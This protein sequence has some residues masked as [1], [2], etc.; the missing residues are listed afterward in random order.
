MGNLYNRQANLEKNLRKIIDTKKA[1]VYP[2]QLKAVLEMDKEEKFRKFQVKKK[3]F[4]KKGSKNK[5]LYLLD[6]DQITSLISYHKREL[7]KIK[8]IKRKNRKKKN[9]FIRNQ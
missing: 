5:P 1:V 7:N 6:S 8:N 2:D 3:N 9:Y 4:N